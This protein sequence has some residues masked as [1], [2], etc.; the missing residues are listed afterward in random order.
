MKTPQLAWDE[1][2]DPCDTKSPEVQ[3]KEKFSE[4]PT[5][6]PNQFQELVVKAF[7][8]GV[9]AIP[10]LE[11]I[12]IKAQKK[13]EIAQRSKDSKWA[14]RGLTCWRN[15]KATKAV[16]KIADSLTTDPKKGVTTGVRYAPHKNVPHNKSI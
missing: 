15:R 8:E 6:L 7:G 9:K 10:D 1:P 16:K 11:L 14:F 5:I 13:L 4:D 12:C 3:I 2:G